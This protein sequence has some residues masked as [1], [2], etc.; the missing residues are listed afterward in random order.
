MNLL[1]ACEAAKAGSTVSLNLPNT[2]GGYAHWNN[3][4]LRWATTK[5]PV[6]VTDATLDGWKVVEDHWEEVSIWEAYDALER[7]ETVE[8]SHFVDS[9]IWYRVSLAPSGFIVDTVDHAHTVIHPNIK[10]RVKQ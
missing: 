6:R 10:W 3:G 1:E 5:A 4:A 2:T 8:R 9:N 7:E